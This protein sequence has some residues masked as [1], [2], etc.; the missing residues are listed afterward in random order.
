MTMVAFDLPEG[1][2]AAL[3]KDPHE[4][5][6][7]LRMAAVAKSYENSQFMEPVLIVVCRD[8][9]IAGAVHDWLTERHWRRRSAA[10]V[11]EPT[12]A[13]GDGAHSDESDRPFRRSII[14]SGRSL[15]GEFH[16]PMNERDAH[17]LG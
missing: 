8:T 3:R 17:A 6:A 16:R 7:E 13:E 1:A 15:D 12:G 11:Q 9:K 14:P 10:L 2:F 5:E 4:M